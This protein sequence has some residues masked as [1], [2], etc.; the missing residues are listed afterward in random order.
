MSKKKDYQELADLIKKD[1]KV[2]V[3]FIHGFYGPLRSLNFIVKDPNPEYVA[4]YL[5]TQEKWV[6]IATEIWEKC[7][8]ATTPMILPWDMLDQC[9]KPPQTF[10]TFKMAEIHIRELLQKNPG[11]KEDPY[12][13]RLGK[14]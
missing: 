2:F 1:G 8:L 13:Y 11:L 3:G 4:E 14:I 9:E 10:N 5:D 7:G 12:F 6:S